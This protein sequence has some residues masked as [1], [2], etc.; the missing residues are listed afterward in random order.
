MRTIFSAFDWLLSQR[1]QNHS[2]NEQQQLCML[3]SAHFFASHSF[4]LSLTPI[5]HTHTHTF[6]HSLTRSLVHLPAQHTRIVTNNVFPLSELFFVVFTFILFFAWHPCAPYTTHLK[7]QHCEISVNFDYIF[8][9][10]FNSVY[11]RISSF[12]IIKILCIVI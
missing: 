4:A 11:N 6:I 12:S 10:A 3:G 5:T 1:I 2:A 8:R 7:P 9:V